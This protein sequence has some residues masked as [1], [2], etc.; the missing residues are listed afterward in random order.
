MISSYSSKEM[1]FDIGSMKTYAKQL[2]GKGKPYEPLLIEIL[3]QDYFYND[4]KPLPTL[5]ELLLAHV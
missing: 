3:N 1:I 4:E 2:I 5:N